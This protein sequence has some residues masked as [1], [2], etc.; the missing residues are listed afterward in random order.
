MKK[1]VKEWLPLIIIA[2]I[3]T[4]LIKR[5]LFFIAYVPTNSM[6]NTIMTG[7][8]L[9][10]TCVHVPEKLKRGD[11][12]VFHFEEAGADLVKRLIGLPGDRIKIVDGDLF[13]NGEK[14]PEPYVKDKDMG[15]Y[16]DGKE[17]LFPMSHTFPG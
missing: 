8:R 12:V 7:E 6:E 11:V 10:V 4:I 15:T 3:L 14:V 9:L 2:L 13:I 16:F 17:L 5:Y 1:L